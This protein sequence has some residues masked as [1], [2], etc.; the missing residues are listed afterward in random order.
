MYSLT[1]FKT[2]FPLRYASSAVIPLTNMLVSSAKRMNVPRSEQFAI[3]FM[4]RRNKSGPRTEPCG[5]PYRTVRGSDFSP[6]ISPLISVY[7]R[8]WRQW[9]SPLATLGAIEMAP[10]DRLDGDT[11]F[12]ITIQSEW[13]IW[14]SN[15]PIDPVA[16]LTT[17]ET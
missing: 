11:E 7:C 1:S 6:L 10:F 15:A 16:P 14:R 4:Y 13:I 2:L 5:T 9:R 3:S 8:H 17:M 12:T